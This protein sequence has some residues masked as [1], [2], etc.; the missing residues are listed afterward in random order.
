MA[1]E[2]QTKWKT[3]AP[4]TQ[5]AAVLNY[6]R[7]K[8]SITPMEAYTELGATRLSA[9][10]YALKRRGYKITSKNIIVTTRYGKTNVCE[11]RLEESYEEEK[12]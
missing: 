10:I 5:R 11:Y 4:T 2:T 6:L 12:N 1:K 3:P 8:G 7:D 9:V